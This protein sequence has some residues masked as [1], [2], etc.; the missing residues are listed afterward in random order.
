[1][2]TS[3]LLDRTR[4]DDTRALERALT[5]ML[6]HGLDRHRDALPVRRA[7]GAWVD[8]ATRMTAVRSDA[9]LHGVVLE[10]RPT[11]VGEAHL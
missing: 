2:L 9:G 7:C 8:V 10:L 5:E 3:N 6:D 11:A 1:M 4:P